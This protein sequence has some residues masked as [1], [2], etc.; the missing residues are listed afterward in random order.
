MP[1][2]AVVDDVCPPNSISRS[3]TISSETP[4][5]LG[6]ALRKRKRKGK[7]NMQAKQINK[8][9]AFEK[10]AEQPLCPPLSF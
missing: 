2:V 6:G 8:H 5:G 7:T 1:P 10:Q 9:I 3:P 4:T